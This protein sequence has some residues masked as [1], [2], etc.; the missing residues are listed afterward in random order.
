MQFHGELD[1]QASYREPA[2]SSPRKRGSSATRKVTIRLTE[3]LCKRLEVAVDRPGVGKSLV[4]AAAL[5]RFFNPA[6]STEDLM[7]ERLDDMHARF[8]RFERDMRM[9]AE[10]VALHARYHL[11]VVPPLP[12]SQQREAT[13]LGD[14]RFKVLAEQVD[15][16]VRLD[17]SLMQETIERLNSTDRGGLKRAKGDDTLRDPVPQHDDQELAP[18]GVDA[19]HISFA[20]AE[21]GGSNSYFRRRRNTFSRPA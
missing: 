10:T 9:M 19:E 21:E 2:V 12:R 14:E 3:E 11:T 13:L 1:M 7:R 18:E 5:E 17:Q 6:P 8:D 20:V 4:V 16:R 15:R